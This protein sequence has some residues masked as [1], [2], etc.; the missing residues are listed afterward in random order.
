M[1][2][3]VAELETDLLALRLAAERAGTA[4][5]CVFSCASEFEA[6][7]IRVRRA[8]GAYRRPNRVGEWVRRGA[9]LAF[10]VFALL[11]M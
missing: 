7:V 2:P 9:L 10:L 11:L 4:L 8:Q 3:T 6:D 5:P 1:T